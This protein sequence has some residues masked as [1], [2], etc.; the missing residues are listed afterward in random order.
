MTYGRGYGQQD[1]Y[2]QQGS[3]Q[4]WPPQYQQTPSRPPQQQ[5]APWPVQQYDPRQHQQRVQGPPPGYAQ[6]QPYAPPAPYQGYPPYALPRHAPAVA[7]KSTAAGLILGLIWP[8]VGCMYAGRVGIG[9]LLMAI[10]LVSIPLIFAF[11]IGFLTGFVTWIVSA[12]LGYTMTREW[13]AAHGIVSLSAGL[14]H[15][16]G[17]R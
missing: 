17:T 1:Q 13:N 11:G 2:P 12:I 10:W 15:P 4:Q 7:P 5:G 3:G 9:I 16:L 6:V 14:E 8:G